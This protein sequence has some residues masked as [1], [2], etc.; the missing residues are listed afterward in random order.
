MYVSRTTVYSNKSDSQ[1]CVTIQTPLKQ[2]VSNLF[3]QLETSNWCEHNL[4]ACERICNNFCS[5]FTFN[6]RVFT[7]THTVMY[8]FVSIIYC[9]NINN[10]WMCVC[11]EQQHCTLFFI[12]Y[13]GNIFVVF[14]G[15]A[16]VKFIRSFYFLWS[17]TFQFERRDNIFDWRMND[18]LFLKGKM[19]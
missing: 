16:K 6:L 13:Q 17:F 10:V 3:K 7:R 18:W 11:T 1:A 19:K 12:S 15:F 8:H 4:S 5:L 2:V 14:S 9:G